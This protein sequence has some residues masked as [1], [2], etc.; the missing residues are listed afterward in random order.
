MVITKRE[1]VTKQGGR[2]FQFEWEWERGGV[3]VGGLFE[4]GRLLTFSAFRMGACSRWA[5]IWRLGAYSNKY[6]TSATQATIIQLS[7]ALKF[8]VNLVSHMTS[9]HVSPHRNETRMI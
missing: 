6:G 9:R 4:A 1:D 8:T 5:L 3:G 7:K 2:I